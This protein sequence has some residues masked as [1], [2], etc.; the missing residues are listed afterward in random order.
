M[1][2]IAK[3]V[4]SI[5]LVATIVLAA[6][7]VPGE[8]DST[9]VTIDG[10][11]YSLTDDG[12]RTATVTANS[13][14]AMS[15]D[16]VIPSSVDYKG[17][18]YTVD[19]LARNF[20]N[21]A[22]L[23]S[24]VLPDT[25]MTLP[26]K[27]FTGCTG[28]KSVTMNGVLNIVGQCF[29]AC[30]SL[31]SVTAESATTIQAYAF[32][33]CSSLTSVKFG[34]L[35]E[36]GNYAFRDCASLT[37][38]DIPE[39]AGLGT[40]P[41]EGTGISK[42]LISG[43]I[44]AYVPAGIGSY[45]IPSSVTTIGGGAFSKV[46]LKELHVPSTVMTVADYG[47]YD[48]KIESITFD[49]NVLG[50][51]NYAFASSAANSSIL[52]SV[53][54]PTAITIINEG[55]FS[56]CC[57]L[58]SITIPKEINAVGDRAFEKC[59]SLKNVDVSSG[60]KYGTKAFSGCSALESFE[61]YDGSEAGANMFAECKSL[62]SVSLCDS[63]T[64]IPDYMLYKCESLTSFEIPAQVK[65]IGKYAFSASGLT[66]ITIPSTLDPDG[67]GDQM[68]RSTTKLEKVTFL[69]SY[70]RIPGYC[71]NGCTSLQTIETYGMLKVVN[72]NAFVNCGN[73]TEI[74]V[75]SGVPF[76]DDNMF[77]KNLS[78]LL[79]DGYLT[80]KVPSGS[81]YATG[82]VCITPSS[83]SIS[84]GSDCVG[85]SHEALA[86]TVGNGG[87]ITSAN[88]S[89][90]CSDGA[91]YMD[92]ELLYVA[93]SAA[94]PEI[95][96]GTARI[97]SLSMSGLTNAKSITI[98][99]SVENVDSYAISSNSNLQTVLFYGSPHLDTEAISLG[100]AKAYFLDGGYDAE[101]CGDIVLSGFFADVD[102]GRVIFTIND[103][104][105]V[106]FTEVHSGNDIAF[107]VA[108]NTGY[109]DSVIQAKNNGKT[110]S[111]ASSG[112]IGGKDI[113]GMFV[114]KG[115]SGD[116]EVIIS[117]VELNLYDVKC[118]SGTGYSFSISESRD[119]V[120]GSTVLFEV[121]C[122]PGYQ[123]S[124]SYAAK[125]D[126]TA[127]KAD[128]STDECRVYSFDILHDTTI[129]V[130]GV[131]EKGKVTVSF[132][133][134]GGSSVSSQSVLMGA[135][136]TVPA[137]PTKSG[138]TFL[139]WYASSERTELYDF[140][141][142]ESSTTVYAKWASQSAAKY[143][144][145]FDAENGKILAYVNGSSATAS[146]G[147]SVVA[148]S[149][150][151]LVFVPNE[152]Y[153]STSW[154]INGAES[155]PASSMEIVIESDTS[156]HVESA[157][158]ATGSFI[159]STGM[160][161]PTPDDYVSSW[162]F[163]SGGTAGAS[164]KNMVYAPA[165]IGGYIYAKNDNVLLK[166]DAD[167][168]RLVKSVK[169]A[170]SF[171][172]FYEYV[173]VG[174]NMVL[175]GITGKVYDTDLNQ[176]FVLNATTAKAFYHDGYFYVETKNGTSCYKAEDSDPSNPT[177]LQ[178]PVWTKDTGSFVTMYEGGTQMVFH[179]GF[180][181]VCGYD[182]DGRD[183]YLQT[184]DAKTGEMIDK[185]YIP[186]FKGQ[187]SNKGYIDVSEGYATVTTYL[188][189]IFDS[190]RGKIYNVASVKIDEN[191]VFDHASLKVRSNGE[192]SSYSSA[193][194]INEGKGY[195]F[196]DGTFSVYDLE[197]MDVLATLDSAKLYAHGSMAISTGHSGKVYAYIVPYVES[198]NLMVIEHDLRT[199]NLTL[200]YMENV[201]IS[202]Y[203]SQQV[204]FLEDGGIV[205]TND[206]GIL[207]CIRHN[208]AVSSISF[209]EKAKTIGVG[210]KYELEVNFNPSNAG[211]RALKWSTS[212]SSVAAVKDG[213]VT[214]VS[215][216][217]AVI[218]ATSS[219]GKTA[220]CT[221]TVGDPTVSVTS[222]SLDKNTASVDVG[223][224][225]TLTATVSPSNA[226][227]RS[228]T[229]STSDSRV[230]TVSN[231]TVKVLSA[232]TTIITV[233]TK[234]GGYTD[235]C[236]LTVEPSSYT[237]TWKNWDGSILSTTTVDKG[238][239]P[240]YDGTP[241]RASDA[242]YTYTFSGWNP[243]PLAATAD[244]EYTASYTQ[245]AVKYT[246]TYKPGSQGSFDAQTYSVTY[247]S[248]TP[249][250][251]G[252]P[253]GNPG[254][255]F[256]DWSPAVS[257]TVTENATYVAQ[258]T[259]SEYTV[260]YLVDGVQIGEK[261]T[262][263]VGDS[264][265]L[266]AAYEKEGFTVSAWET[267]Q[268]VYF[269]NGAFLMPAYDITFD[270]T[271]T[272]VK[273][274]VTWKNWDGSILA[275]TSV[276]YGS[277]PSYTGTAPSRTADSE[278]TYT[279]SG[280]NPTVR[281]ITSNMT[282]TA[283]FDSIPIEKKTYQIAWKNWDGSVLLT[284]TVEEGVIPAYVG[285][286]PS[287]PSDDKYSYTFDG[288][289]PEPTAAVSDAS[290]TATYS[291]SPMS[292]TVKYT[293]DGVQYGDVETHDYSESVKLR[294]AYE[295]EG[296]EVSDWH[297]EQT[298][299]FINGAFMMPA[300]NVTFNATTTIIELAVTWKNWDG[301]TLAK[302]SVDY[303][304]T[305]SYTGTAPSR[306]ADSEYTYT[307]SGWSPSVGPITDD[308]TYTAT[309][310]AIPV[311][312]KTY[313]IAWKNWD[314][315]V[316]AT[317]TVE[318]G[319]V[320]SYAGTE[321]ARAAD[322]SYTYEFAGWSPRPVA[323]TSDAAYTA[324]FLPV[325]IVVKTYTITWKNWD[326]SVLSTSTVEDGEVPTYGGNTPSKPA[327]AS[328]TYEFAGWSPRPVAAAS[329]AAYTAVFLPVPIVVKTYTITWKNWDGSVLATSMV[330]EDQTPAYSGSAPSKP[331][332]E[333]FTYEFAGWS[334][335]PV[336]TTSDAAYTAVFVPVPIVVKTYTITWVN[337]NNAVL[338][339]STVEK[340]EIP[341]YS[342]TPT[343]HATSQ[344]KFTFAGWSPEPVAA[345]S[346]ATYTATYDK[347]PIMHAVTY[348][349]DGKQ[350]G[351]VEKYFAGSNVKIR[352]AYEGPFTPW[353]PLDDVNID[354]GSF[355]MPAYDVTFVSTSI[356]SSFEIT[357]KNWDG[358]VLATTEAAYGAIPT[359][360]GAEPTRASD[361]EHSYS[362]AGWN[363]VPI[364]A[365]SD[366]VYTATYEATEPV[367]TVTY[368]VDGVQVGDIE[369]HTYG[370][371][372]KL[373]EIYA[374]EGYEVSGWHSEQTVYFINGAFLMPAYDITYESTT[375]PL[376]FDITW[377]N[378][379]GSSLGHTTASY[380][381]VPA[382]SGSTPARPSD[383]SY[384]YA[385]SGWSPALSAAKADATY[386]ATY[387]ATAI[388]KHVTGI[389][390]DKSTLSISE[391]MTSK[392]SATVSPSDA[393]DSSVVWT[394]S[395]ESIVKVDQNGNVTA[396]KEGSATITAKT[397][398][399]GY[400]A[401]C[402]VT[403]GS[404]SETQDN[405]WILIVGAIAA[406]VIVGAIAGVFLLRKKP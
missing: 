190:Q 255:T 9:T 185:I 116:T 30:T 186:E 28:L 348:L 172:G 354:D 21:N 394:S 175:D 33:K 165:I 355:P 57:A 180:I 81:G 110:V 85:F 315:S 395:D 20:A 252:T 403:V 51:G 277:T 86:N 404:G 356:S 210:E 300:Y 271:C 91:V 244:A 347:T 69:G 53:T 11:E 341:T 380:G 3:A 286:E 34:E 245:E 285:T 392:I 121:R 119:V 385:F 153:E 253:A 105:N 184:S 127:A 375:T 97:D 166:I 107:S 268:T 358:S 104:L 62:R 259:G 289:N 178:A 92:N 313:T 338:A 56:N 345:T 376:V 18:S 139:G 384:S 154:S 52:K 223:D 366:A 303:G 75:H 102:S 239:V 195:V 212:D 328:C 280:W 29:S 381:E 325:P 264:V 275:K 141:A 164:F 134:D 80:V 46:A 248:A 132:D 333:S 142:V 137:A 288:W 181:M 301:S 283:Q 297:S 140:G 368:L 312:A 54:L 183:V 261:E 70:T 292:Y 133:T 319:T 67:I 94:S 323:A 314:G 234:D 1:N 160:N 109:T 263:T 73:L 179:N 99:E 136:A 251:S 19:T 14:T 23:T 309:F 78:T 204:H 401:S 13:I 26:T 68:L 114:L 382:Y 173:A 233:T 191:G 168:G 7:S 222:V 224:T 197:T 98:P 44:L 122:L 287:K 202:Q 58:E 161:T 55:S 100:G 284:S 307:F 126:G 111:I 340:G 83:T 138:Y 112:T 369:T 281:P 346:N 306:T 324:V 269:I 215:F 152:G 396:V 192:N 272:P 38:F 40:A 256:S 49:K 199:N 167:D 327:D 320:P 93:P 383:D 159:N 89:I 163:G 267:E 101:K 250:F 37:S 60:I 386:T 171:S 282:Y 364:V 76:E 8:A 63:M 6:V 113:T 203:S 125:V 31:K 72:F 27:C 158:Y 176:L 390:L 95:K 242:R 351:D 39:T 291:S 47:F 87:T 170:G 391:G 225:V 400:T 88:P 106:D 156:V 189:G 249:E 115:V 342:G 211:I 240:S 128:Y 360:T 84:V 194:I 318:E 241:F 200:S 362:F 12:G 71:F 378:W 25:I 393:T 79:K 254:Y 370:E 149:I 305:P 257:A 207:Y 10:I 389:S 150:A 22:N 198:P 372:V 61:F 232:G 147:T 143:K 177:N 188:S 270:A 387:K 214:G 231:G 317:S 266:R 228:V 273:L 332:D 209:D 90:V 32:D 237:I 330:E 124:S 221:I 42:P 299:Y 359:Y 298:V 274:A 216:G 316:L 35:T 120:H 399:G 230:A 246:V 365:T 276:D 335:R 308:A 108:P 235:T 260:T 45:T 406:V 219:N 373:R 206:R 344:Y 322:S 82:K 196:S 59:T 144:L 374:K 367:Y 402:A 226:T 262:Y 294:A 157:Y 371:A 349:V 337:W 398:D 66:E 118:P 329:D 311:V 148:G 217:T 96:E 343:R 43:G 363:P 162:M 352:A 77:E 377:K 208:I 321:P 65:T 131:T 220:T 238:E 310:N 146:S 331:A 117:G 357:W 151:V 265:K 296:Y 174:G 339:T 350:V 15:G 293:V 205:Y 123:F 278:Y 236:T 243:T 361:A 24:I 295:K 218:T 135:S 48:A 229:W 334:P 182:E 213:T 130:A 187:Y 388:S 227:D 64:A 279:F 74:I 302:T 405:Q 50:V 353:N 247:G 17:K 145:T 379:D 201:A 326:G 290:Y 5:F 41:F 258:W 155:G 169:T 16:V 129:A 397:N 2:N 4:L 336:A 193:M 36:I 304:S 103:P